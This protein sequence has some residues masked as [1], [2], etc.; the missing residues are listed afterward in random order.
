MEALVI[1]L[2]VFGKS[3]SENLKR[4]GAVVVGIDIDEKV[5]KESTRFLDQTVRTDATLEDSLRVLGVE[6][7]DYVFV[8]IGVDMQAS[9]LV[10]LH[11]NNLGA[12]KIIARSNSAEHSL[13]LQRLGANRVI[14]PEIETGKRL[15]QEITSNFSSFMQFSDNFAVV[16]MEVMKGMVGK[17]LRELDLRQKHKVNVL[18]IRKSIPYVDSQGE[19][20][21]F[22]GEEEVPSPDYRFNLFDKIFVMGDLKNIRKFMQSFTVESENAS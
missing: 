22:K 5:I 6:N 10:T 17:N 1:G 2:G 11:L 20:S 9:L 8:C 14:T 19:D 15:A 16:Q 3:L 21:V 4:Q 13:I 12:R 7:F 18:S